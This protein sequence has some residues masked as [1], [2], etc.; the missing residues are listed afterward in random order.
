MNKYYGFFDGIKNL[1]DGKIIECGLYDDIFSN[2][3]NALAGNEEI[4]ELYAE[5]GFCVGKNILEIAAGDGSNY[6]IPLAQK[7]FNVDG[8]EISES[9]IDRFNENVSKLPQRIKKKL[10]MIQADIF[11][12]ETDK[13]YDLIT[14]PSTTICLLSDDVERLE[15][16][17]D[18]IYSWL[19]PNGRL[20]FDYRTDQVTE[21]LYASNI[22]TNTNLEDKYYIVLQE[23]NNFVPEKS[24]VNMYVEKAD[25]SKYLACSEKKIITEKF[26]D[27][28]IEKT[29]FKKHYTYH[30]KEGDITIDVCVLNKEEV[31]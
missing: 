19:T 30:V 18:K 6:M 9:M 8:V 23:F 24:I 10:N 22:L 17:F 20:M 29:C 1:Y 28:V 3:Y 21:R 4:K 16:L 2:V 11:D 7:G 13:K 12:Y 15:N 5:N 25:G 14:I 31:A 26:V 27:S